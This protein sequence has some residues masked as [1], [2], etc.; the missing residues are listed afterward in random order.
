MN[1]K[2]LPKTELPYEGSPPIDFLSIPDALSLILKEQKKAV[3]NVEKEIKF[4]E[5]AAKKI[6]KHLKKSNKGRIIY[7]GAGTSAR[8][9]VQDGAELFPTFGWPL[10]RVDFAIAGGKEALYRSVE[11]AE[12]DIIS[13]RKIIRNLNLDKDDVFI[14]IAASGN[15]PFTLEAL[16]Q[17]CSKKCLTLSI[18]NNEKGAISVYSKLKI[19]LNTSQEV[20]A[21]STR[22]KA[23]TAQKICLNLL[24][25]IIMIM[26]GKVESGLMSNLVVNNQKLK[27]RQILIKK[28]LKNNL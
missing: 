28:L 19:I 7:C 23:G 9:G 4:I 13:A 10:E 24:S 26:M 14:A 25:T 2:L 5:N 6:F 20:I 18:S 8:I 1:S 15:T 3:L 21:G 11:N 27:K 17:A 16:K 12:D 22:L